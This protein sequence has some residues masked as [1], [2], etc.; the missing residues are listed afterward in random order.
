[1][2]SVN[3]PDVTEQIIKD[4]IAEHKAKIPRYNKLLKYYKAQHDISE[5]LP[6]DG[7]PNNKIINDYPGYI[8]DTIQ[9][10]FIGIPVQYS[11]KDEKLLADLNSIFDSNN[12]E[13]HN[14]EM[15]KYMGVYGEAY[16]LL[17]VNEDSQIRF[18]RLKNEETILVFD[19]DF[20]RSIQL[21]LRYY[22]LTG[23]N[24]KKEI[25]KVELYYPDK[26]EYYTGDDSGFNLDDTV[27]HYF[28]K[29]PVVYYN[30][31]DECMGDFEKVLSLI[32]D[33]DKRVSDNSNELEEFRNAYL[34]IK[35]M[36]GTDTE[37]LR[38]MRKMGAI[39]V[40]AD[41]DASFIEKKV[42]DAYTEHHI[43]RLN[44]NI[45]K[46]SKVPDLSDENFAGNLSGVAIKYKLWPIEQIAACKE[47][48]FKTGL[49]RRIKLI[50][51]ILSLQSKNYDWKSIDIKFKRNIPSN[52]LELSQIAA[53]INGLVSQETLLSIFPFVEN[54]AEEIEKLQ[55][56]QQDNTL[57]KNLD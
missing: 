18:V 30:N 24:T 40:E 19:T 25:L 36:S 11:G 43:Q 13:D 3:L 46:F 37:D 27:P 33:Y 14:A 20:Q 9:G 26:V 48:K 35:N 4:L 52:V 41:G 22:T 54:A 38:E 56:E 28:G 44:N 15:A 10:Y 31:N 6:Q 16:E 51:N 17:Y 21:A 12:E 42:D 39:K 57:Y 32:D 49:K 8:I 1:M 53:N 47:R 2:F 7:K 45:H 29:V 5:R 23:R 34:K 50:S 55:A